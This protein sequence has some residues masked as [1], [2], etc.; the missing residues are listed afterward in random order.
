MPSTSLSAGLNLNH[1]EAIAAIRADL[2]A[3]N[4]DAAW[5]A[6]RAL[7]TET[8]RPE[9]LMALALLIGAIG[10]SGISGVPRKRVAILGDVTTN[11]ISAASSVALAG[12]GILAEV[13]DAPFGTLRQQILDP[14]RGALAEDPDLVVLVP[15]PNGAAQEGQDSTT[16]ADVW[17]GLWAK[18]ETRLPEARIVHHLFEPPDAEYLGIAERRAEWTPLAQTIATNRALIAAAPPS[19]HLIDMEALANKVGRRSWHDP[20]LWHHGRVPFASPHVDDYR[21]ELQAAFRRA[22]GRVRKALVVDLDNTLWGGVVGDDGIDGIALGP[23]SAAGEA[24]AAFCEY[25][26]ELGRRGVILGICSKN[27]SSALAVFDSHPHMRLRR[28]DFAAVRCNWNDKATNLRSISAEL[29]I[30]VSSIVY[31]DDNPAECDLIR[32]EIPSISVVELSGDPSGFVRMLDS[33]KLFQIDAF[34][35]DDLM[36]KKSYKARRDAAVA[37]DQE[38]NLPDYLK[39]LEMHASFWEAC[40]EDLVRL[41]QMELKTNQFNTTNMRYTAAQIQ[42]FMADPSYAVFACRLGDRFGDHGL[43]SSVVL[44]RNDDVACIESWLMSCRVF[45]RTLE[46]YM[47]CQMV[48]WA[49]DKGIREVAGKYKAT[50][51]NMVIA[52]LFTRLGFAPALPDGATEYR[53]QISDA[54]ALPVH[55]IAE[56]R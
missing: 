48:A 39:S 32:R 50:D 40:P 31:V 11:S 49:K 26:G 25:V 7:V 34:S 24:Y 20:R 14:E 43:V 3:G 18:I 6:V 54:M 12:E 55:F 56:H 28:D 23:G 5:V 21:R 42:Q 46:E 4:P 45:S 15:L 36:R 47:L 29:N 37:R 41:S 8:L 27:E 33:L 2:R 1:A 30:D 53:L 51:R 9:H 13:L 16:T 44:R 17:R 19:V 38:T 10:K 52:N 35:A 22:L